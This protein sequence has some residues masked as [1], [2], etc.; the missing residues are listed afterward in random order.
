M[1]YAVL[2][3]VSTGVMA[4]GWLS[5]ILFVSLL[6]L[7]WRSMSPFRL[8]VPG[9]AFSAYIGLLLVPALL[10]APGQPDEEAAKRFVEFST[11]AGVAML[12]GMAFTSLIYPSPNIDLRDYIRMPILEPNRPGWGLVLPFFLV[13]VLGASA[14]HFLQRMTIPFVHMLFNLHSYSTIQAARES[15]KALSEQAGMLTRMQFYLIAWS[16]LLFMPFIAITAQAMHQSTQLSRWRNLFLISVCGAMFLAM[17]EADK[18]SGARMAA[19]LLGATLLIRSR[20]SWKIIVAGI[21]ALALPIVIAI[22]IHPENIERSRIY[23]SMADR[24][25][26][27]PAQVTYYYFEAFPKVYPHTLGRSTFVLGSMLGR[28]PANLPLMISAYVMGGKAKTVY[29]N[30]G[31]IGTGW[32]EFGALG[33][34]GY[35][36]AA[37]MLAQAIQN[38]IMRRAVHGKKIGWVIFQAFQIPM[39]TVVLASAGITEF[40]LGRGLMLAFVLAWWLDRR[41]YAPEPEGGAVGREAAPTHSMGQV[42]QPGGWRPPLQAGRGP[43]R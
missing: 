38:C 39:W 42:R 8:S 26:T 20:L 25:F 24:A 13:L 14:M 2:A 11:L 34:F 36:L 33:V 7:R 28:E 37:G 43:A 23:D 27:A 10:L 30:C 3:S 31:F 19:M 17:W 29:M 16:D 6:L 35:A 15:T 32:A 22:A 41:W 5:V 1:E 21:G 40:F 18:S 4:L 9:I 12:V